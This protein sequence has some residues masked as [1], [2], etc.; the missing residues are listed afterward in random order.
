MRALNVFTLVIAL[1][2]GG[3]VGAEPGGQTGEQA[4]HELMQKGADDLHAMPMT[5]ELEHDFI[6]AARKQDQ[7]AI[8]M[9]R[10]LLAHANEPGA[11]QIAR[12]IV[13]SRTKEVAELDR[14]MSKHHQPM[15]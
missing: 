11:R 6:W 4:L 1:G 3:T 10:L 8:D 9:A 12:Q 7:N 2:F 5:G 15:K 14:W 13:E